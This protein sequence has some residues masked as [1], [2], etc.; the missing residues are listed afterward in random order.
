MRRSKFSSGAWRRHRRRC[1]S[2]LREASAG[3]DARNV[4]QMP[5]AVHKDVN[6]FPSPLHSGQAR[7]T[8]DASR[9]GA[10]ASYR[11]NAWEIARAV[12]KRRR[13]PV[14]GERNRNPRGGPPHSK[15]ATAADSQTARFCATR[16]HRLPTSLLWLARHWSLVRRRLLSV[17]CHGPR[18]SR[19]YANL[20]SQCIACERLKGSV[21]H[22]CAESSATSALKKLSR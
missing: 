16:A 14:A 19:S 22:S 20:C 21:A 1:S 11:G 17:V 15:K 4:K 10:R 2:H 6:G 7:Q 18:A 13:V 9:C 3:T 8:G 5:H 12:A